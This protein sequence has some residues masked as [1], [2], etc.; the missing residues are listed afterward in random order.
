MKVLQV[1]SVYKRGS[2]G[3]IVYDIHSFLQEKGIDSVVCYGRGQKECDVNIYKTSSEISAKFNALRSRITGLQFN[4]AWF[5]TYKLIKIIKKEQP[6]IVHLQCINGYFVDIYKLLQFLKKNN[7]KTV[8]TL[9][10]E[11]M[12][13]GNCGHSFECE[14]W[15]NGC[16][17]CPQLWYA[18]K[19]YQFDRTKTAWEKMK[20][21]FDGFTNL[22]IISV[23]KWLEDRAK[24]SP[25]L[26]QHSF[27]VIYNGIDTAETFKPT[28]YNN[29]KEKHGLEN[30]KILLHVTANFSLGEN[31]LKGGR[32]IA[33]L[34]ER[35]K[36]KNIKIVVI[37][38]EDLSVQL[39]SNVINVGRTINQKE[40]AAYYSM[41]DLTL[42]TSKRETFSMVCA[43]SLSCGTPVVGFKAGGPE[44]IALNN[45]SK[46]V[47]YGDIDEL[48][49]TVI[50][51]LNKKIEYSSEDIANSAQKEYSRER[52]G[53]EYLNVYNQLNQIE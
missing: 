4:G 10:A 39:P 37:G 52:M 27:R 21:A 44:S 29:L 42:I 33:S 43:E 30:E 35:L 19:S 22:R 32:Y 23:S 31:D 49:N 5:A 45:F 41:A 25:I 16:G 8:L 1:N 3:K 18:T 47:N 2:T 51:W 26:N 11:F 46:F 9:H 13:T 24:I 28:K 38:S 6:D 12:H 17:N 48:E 36:D 40:L 14:K 15:K 50:N 7:V 53:L 20:E 34:A